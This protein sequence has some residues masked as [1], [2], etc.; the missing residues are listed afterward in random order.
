[1]QHLESAPPRS[2]P[3]PLARRY[4]AIRARALPGAPGGAEADRPPAQAAGPP[5]RFAA[6]ASA[7]ERPDG[8]PA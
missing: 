2:A 8:G 6:Q 4:R 5:E 7:R 3:A 1:M